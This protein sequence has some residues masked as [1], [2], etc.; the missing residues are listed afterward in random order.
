MTKRINLYVEK[1]FLLELFLLIF[2]KLLLEF[3]YIKF[4]NKVYLYAGF[5]LDI[6]AI[7]YIFGWIIFL[8]CYFILHKQRKLYIF[9]IYLLLFLLY[10]LPNVVFYSL[11]SQNTSDFLTLVLP[12]IFLVFAN[13]NK[14]LFTIYKLKYGK[15]ML[16]FITI[17]ILGIVIYNYYLHTGGN[18]VVN[19]KK[20]YQFRAL[21]DQN[22]NT[23]IFGYINS[24][25]MKIFAVFL[26]AW[27]LNKGKLLLVF[28]SLSIILFLFIFSGHKSVLQGIII[29]LFFYILFMFKD[30]GLILIF[31]FF[32]LIALTTFLTLYV[33]QN[34]IGSIII[35][36]LLFVPVNLNFI[37][38]EY[39]SHNDFIYWSNSVLKYFIEY[40]FEVKVT[41]IIGA[42]L[43]KP[44]MAANTGSFASGYMHAEYFGVIIYTL[45]IS[46][47]LYFINIM[48]KNMDK[49]IV[50][51]IITIP[52]ITM[53]VSSDLL[54]SLLTHGLLI[55][56]IILWLYE[57]DEYRIKLGFFKFK[58]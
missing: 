57:H 55:S 2:T 8:G 4:L 37:Y 45:I 11:S 29:V 24:W 47:V 41:K 7:K 17:L 48:A 53:F 12:F 23:G 40:P 32:S 21:Y 18:Y 25:A 56:M 30:R 52:I 54:T 26:F 34:M 16:F 50:L 27:S 35:R 46:A 28:F 31:G 14:E 33:N 22:S 3:I 51:A 43:D 5:N 36:R 13:S 20:V 44:D 19:F 9:E 1:V 49:Y 10:F 58:I 6:V 42:Y 39:F 38:F 15:V